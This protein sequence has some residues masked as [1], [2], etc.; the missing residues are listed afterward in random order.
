[1]IAD[2]DKASRS[3]DKEGGWVSRLYSATL[4]RNEA[5]D[6][7]SLKVSKN[8]ITLRSQLSEKGRGLELSELQYFNGR[9][10][11]V[12]DR[13]GI[14]YEISGKTVVPRHILADGDGTV[15]KG[16]KGEWMAVKNRRLYIGGMGKEWTTPQGQ[17]INLNPQWIKTISAAG[18]VNHA[19][20]VRQYNALRSA[21][22]MPPPGYVLHESAAWSEVR[23]RWYFLPRHASADAYDDVAD[24]MRGQNLVLSADADFNDVQVA[25][26]GP[27]V[28]EHGFSSFK[29]VPGT[30]DR[31][32]VAL[33][34]QELKGSIASFMAVYDLDTGKVLMPEAFVSN[35]KLEGVEF[36]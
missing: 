32:I 12:D 18:V 3:S 26:V 4:L 30:R 16:F 10:L 34:T 19:S 17:V 33:K 1:M 24:E 2:L 8:I 5:T 22:R 13:T 27:R 31:H 7:Y 20:W 6:M 9:L 21:A 28:R 35:D 29:F 15:T 25:H 11:T 14:V 23:Q 36:V